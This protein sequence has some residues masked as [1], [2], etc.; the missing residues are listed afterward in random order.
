LRNRVIR[1]PQPCFHA[2]TEF[3]ERKKAFLE[4]EE[5][6]RRKNGAMQVPDSILCTDISSLG[7]PKGAFWFMFVRMEFNRVSIKSWS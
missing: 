5:Q 1:F 3:S 4:P 6:Y 2:Y 7:M